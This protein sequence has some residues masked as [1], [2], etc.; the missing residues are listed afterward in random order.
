MGIIGNLSTNSDLVSKHI[1]RDDS[2]TILFHTGQPMYGGRT[3]CY[4]GLTSEAYG[5]LAK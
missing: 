5:T 1:D 4:T 2:I 3:D